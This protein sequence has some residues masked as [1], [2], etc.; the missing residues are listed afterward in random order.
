MPIE[1][2]PTSTQDNGEQPNTNKPFEKMLSMETLDILSLVKLRNA[3]ATVQREL[4]LTVQT[5]DEDRGPAS[6]TTT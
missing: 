1:N 2:H 3:L 6:H 4:I 5:I